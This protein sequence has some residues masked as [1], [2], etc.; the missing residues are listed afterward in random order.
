[1]D[2]PLL[3][4]GRMG[5]G[6]LSSE[7]FIRAAPRRWGAPGKTSDAAALGRADALVRDRRHVA[8]RRDVETDGLQ[9]A[10]RRFT[11]GAGAL[12]F[13]FQRAA[14][15]LGGLLAGVSGADLRRHGSRLAGALEPLHA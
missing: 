8:D 11:A 1:M 7:D 2:F 5:V 14:A 13:D 3:W 12:D 9:R 10:D 4:A 6:H 15:K